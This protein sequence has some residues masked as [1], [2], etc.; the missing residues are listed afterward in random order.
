MRRIFPVVALAAIFHLLGI[1]IANQPSHP[2]DI[3]NTIPSVSFS[4]HTRWSNPEL[5]GSVTRERIEDALKVLSPLTKKVRTYTVSEG[6]DLVPELADRMGFKVALGIWVDGDDDRTRREIKRGVELA[7]KHPSVIEI[8]VGN[9]AILSKFRKP[10]EMMA[11]MREVQLRTGKPVSTAEP[12]YIWLKHPEMAEAADFLAIHL[13]AFWSGLSAKDAAAFAAEHYQET[14]A[15]FPGQRV[16]IAEYGWPSGRSNRFESRP[17]QGSQALAIRSFAAWATGQQID[18]NLV[19]AFDQPW[20]VGEGVVGPY[21]GIFDVDLNPKFPMAGAVEDDSA[22]RIRGSL[23][24]LLGVMISLVIMGILRPQRW[25]TT[26]TMAVMGQMIGKGMADVA[27]WPLGGY[28]S[29]P[30][31][32][33]WTIGLP[34]MSLVGVLVYER[35][36]EVCEVTLEGVPTQQDRSAVASSQYAPKVSIHLPACRE[37]PEVVIA[38]LESLGRL[39]WP[40]FEVIVV[41][42][43]TPDDLVA[44]VRAACDRLGSRFRLLDFP[45]LAGFKSGALNRALEAT[46]QDAEVIAI[47]DADYTVDKAWLADLVPWFADPMIAMV[48][49]PQD[50]RNGDRSWSAM[51]MDREYAGFFDIG[52]VQRA[53]DNASVTHG[54]MLLLR[55]TALVGIG[56][57]DEQFICEDTHLGLTLLEHGWRAA[58]TRRRYGAG[59]LPDDFIA[60]RSQRWRWAYGAMRIM[61]AHWRSM[62]PGSRTLTPAQKWHFMVGWMHWLGD[63]LAI[64]SAVGCA[65]WSFWV[66]FSGLGDLP[67]PAVTTAILVAILVS[68]AHAVVGYG[69]RVRN[70]WLSVWLAILASM[71]L[72]LTIARGVMSGIFSPGKPFRVTAK[73]GKQKTPWVRMLRE[74]LPE[75]V[76]ATILL[77][78]FMALFFISGRFQDAPMVM[79]EI[80]LL[81]QAM[82]N[83]FAIAM[84][85]LDFFS[86]IPNES[87]NSRFLFWTRVNF[88]KAR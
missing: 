64:I 55:R 14:V 77:S 39:E 65:L 28:V 2:V 74:I 50:H 37:R 10:E 54:T 56:G 45:I 13:L 46:S 70:G 25:A 30:E 38:S 69:L 41:T 57:W 44:P 35:I 5:G 85:G 67:P 40:N 27:T 63:A 88:P 15:G 12:W 42:N 71:S 49:A 84:A 22:W 32:T 26:I 76:M 16:W 79:L 48:Q 23:A 51:A 31:M 18:W 87:E 19:E 61:I 29:L 81:A 47:L 72:Q 21:W 1:W 11:L 52:M 78:A 17:S 75:A 8:I 24:A 80:T 6:L 33:M 34:M 86:K 68:T 53:K 7:K 82:P 58:Y 83:I 62:L 66:A 9:E 3:P 43:N 20:K 73:G 60:F 4:P 59:L 36:R